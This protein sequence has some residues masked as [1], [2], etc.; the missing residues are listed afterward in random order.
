MSTALCA[1]LAAL[2]LALVHAAR[3]NAWREAL[4]NAGAGGA[5]EA[6]TEVEPVSVVVPARD[7]A[8]TLVPLLQDLH[9]QTHRAHMEVIVVDDHSSDGTVALVEA[10]RPRW[11]DLRLVRLEEAAGKKA[12]LSAGIAAARH[13]LVLFTDADA[14]CGPDRVAAIARHRAVHDWDLLVAPV[15]T[16]GE[17]LL[18]LVQVEE[19]VALSGAAVGTWAE[20]APLI[21][22]GANLAVSREAFTAVG[23]YT[24]DR[25]AGG[26]DVFL[27]HRLRRHG[28]PTALSM[29]P[30]MMVTV[31]AEPT[32][33]G[34]LR[35]RLRWAGKMR[36]VRLR[37]A[38]LAAGS[39][40]LLP[41]MLLGL[42]ALVLRELRLGQGALFTLGT[43]CSAW[44][45][46]LFPTVAMA[47]DARRILFGHAAPL[48]SALALLAF[49][50]LAPLIALA[51]L[52]VR[53]RWK[54]RRV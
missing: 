22:Y 32:R 39:G 28:R 31:E 50:V 42:S 43:L 16:Q 51:S 8:E 1:A 26:D 41:W 11:P 21:A 15:R 23:G 3:M 25:W 48:R 33:G 46:W 19:Q 20:G 14:R 10:M 47:G 40:V 17:G 35:Q 34:F 13:G 38:T 18:G 27:L 49:S 12:A 53:P 36:G 54:G 45:A 4:R 7:A 30:A 37:G 2:A 6:A 29:D 9:A 44:C 52:V 5:P 24:G